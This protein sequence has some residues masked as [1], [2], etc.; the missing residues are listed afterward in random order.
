MK[1]LT[2]DEE[3]LFADDFSDHVSIIS[4]DCDTQ[5]GKL[6][7]TILEIDTNINSRLPISDVAIF[8][9]NDENRK[10]GVEVGPICFE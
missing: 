6:G 3:E 7:R 5:N 1:I 9:D 10:F 2:N 4:D 8:D